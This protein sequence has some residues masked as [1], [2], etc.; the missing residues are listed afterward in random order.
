MSAK[1]RCGCGRRMREHISRM[2]SL[3][4]PRLHEPDALAAG[5][6]TPLWKGVGG[7]RSGLSIPGT[8]EGWRR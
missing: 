2:L 8:L 4:D 5:D 7:R 1:T 6:S 3:K